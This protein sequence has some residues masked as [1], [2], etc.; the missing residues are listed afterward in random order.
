MQNY[1]EYMAL[2]E[3]VIHLYNGIESKKR[4]FGLGYELSMKEIHTIQYIGDQPNINVTALAS[5][6]G[7][8]KGAAS[9]MISRLVKKGLVI[10][11]K[12]ANSDLE[13]VLRLTEEGQKAYLGHQA[14]H[15]QVENKMLALTD[16]YTDEE[17]VLFRKVLLDLEAAILDFA[18]DV[19]IAP[20]EKE[21]EN[22]NN[23][24]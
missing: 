1:Q 17:F 15:R 12:A 23:S 5:K 2:L 7:V 18:E 22:E 14:F 3:R 16:K 11:E 24:R 4:D 8:T 13:I 9:Q 10:K 6:Q 21:V 20:I 19:S